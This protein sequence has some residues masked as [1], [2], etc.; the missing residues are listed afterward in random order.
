MAWKTNSGFLVGQWFSF[1]FALMDELG[2]N[3]FLFQDPVTNRRWTSTSYRYCHLFP[4]LQLQKNA[5]DPYL[6]KI[7]GSPGN[8]FGDRFTMFHL[9]RRSGRSHC[10]LHRPGCQRAATTLE[11][12]LHGR[13]RF[14]N[15]GREAIDLH[16][17]EPT[18]E[19]R[20]YLT[21]LCF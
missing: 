8:T 18:L 10:R 19:D 9:Y 20:I 13:W 21:L 2:I 15:K 16:Y 14:R 3:D 12:Y 4:L 1:L 7:D 17:L 6:S 11:T 5:S